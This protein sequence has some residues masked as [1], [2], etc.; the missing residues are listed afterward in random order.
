LLIFIALATIFWKENFGYKAMLPKLALWILLVPFTWWFVQWTISLSSVI[1]ASVITIPHEALARITSGNGWMDRPIIPWEFVIDANTK[2]TETGN[3][4]QDCSTNPTGCKKPIEVLRDSSGIYGHMMIYAYGVF[5]IQEIKKLDTVT[6]KVEAAVKIVHD[7]IIS[8]IMFLVFWILTL[9][10]VFMLLA[11]AIMLWVYT[12]FSP[13]MT[14]ELVMGW[15]LKNISKDFSIKEFVWLAF[16]PALVGLALSF[17]LVMVSA[18]QSPLTQKQDTCGSGQLL[19]VKWCTLATLMWNPSNKIVRRLEKAWDKYTTINE[20][21]FGWL[22]FIYKGKIW[23][24]T[25]QDVL[26]STNQATSIISS[27][28][29]MFGKIIVDIVALLFIWMAFMAAKKVSSVVGAA[30]KPFEEMWEKIGKLW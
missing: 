22:K 13:F 2:P 11:R 6:D 24:A 23:G 25:E 17:W 1:T 21:H 10:L 8:I 7:G 20:V 19:T 14:L 5:R 29:G 27:T 18:V 3:T 16:V 30:A 4:L 26:S 15:A 9:A 12:I 28:G